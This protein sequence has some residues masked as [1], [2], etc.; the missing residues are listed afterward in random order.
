MKRENQI[1]NNT[2]LS[3]I[4]DVSIIN[5]YCV[6]IATIVTKISIATMISTTPTTDAII[7][8]VSKNLRRLK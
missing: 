1:Y 5:S 8:R 6:F 4:I 2:Y 3:C 7:A